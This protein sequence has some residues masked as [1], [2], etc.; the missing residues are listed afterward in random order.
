M[1]D[2]VYQERQLGMEWPIALIG[3]LLAMAVPAFPD[4]RAA[5]G[6]ADT[7]FWLA[8]NP[9]TWK[10]SFKD[11]IFLKISLPRRIFLL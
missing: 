1:Y 11:K 2:K 8:V 6:T 4:Y 3:M 5:L 7:P 10:A 9:V